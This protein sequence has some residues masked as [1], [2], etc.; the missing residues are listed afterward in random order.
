M[1]R[2][3]SLFCGAANLARQVFGISFALICFVF[4]QTAAG[5]TAPEITAL[6]L[7]VPV[8]GEI[9]AKEKRSYQI[10]LAENQFAALTVEQRGI[11]VVVR[12]FNKTD[13]RAMVQRDL[14]S[15][16]E[17]REEIN[18]VAAAAGVYRLEIEG[19]MMSSPT[20]NY[21]VRLAEVRPPTAKELRLEE[22]RK[23]HNEAFLLWRAGK[24][25]EAIPLS[26]RSLAIREKEL[27]AE[28]LDVAGSL[29]NLA[30]IV[31]E[32][33]DY[34]RGVSLL[35]RAL[36]IREKF[37]GPEHLDLTISL[38]NLGEGYRVLGDYAKAEQFQ[39]RALAIREKNFPPNHPNIA[40]SISNLANLYLQKGDADKALEFELRALS[41][42]EKAFG[43]DHPNTA[44]SLNGLGDVHS[45][46]TDYKSAEVC[47]LRALSILQKNFGTDHPKTA[48][49]M[50]NLAMLYAKQ[51]DYAKAEPLLRQ[52]LDAM[53]KTVGKEHRHYALALLWL[54]TVYTD[55]GEYQ[56]AEPL[57]KQAIA[58][59]EKLFGSQHLLVILC[60]NDLARNYQ[61][62]GETAKALEVWTRAH[63]LKQK[64]I[65]LTLSTNSERQKLLY[66]DKLFSETNQYI[67]A[68]LRFAPDNP[69]ALELALTTIFESKGRVSDAMATDFAALRS[70]FNKD[71][72]ILLDKLKDVTNQLA[73]KTL[74]E[75]PNVKPD[76][77]QKQIK[78]LEEEKERLEIEISRRSSEFR[79][80]IQ[81]VTIASIRA[82][83]PENA[84]LIEFGIYYPYDPKVI[85]SKG[86]G[87]PRY[88]AYVIRREGKIQWKDL[89]AA[90][91][92]DDA[93]ENFR[94]ALSDKER[95]DVRQIARTVDEKVMQPVRGLTGD[96]A[97]LLISPDGA[98]NLIPFEAL[99]DEQNKYLVENYSFTYLTGGRDLLRMQVQRTSKNKSLVIANPT[100]GEPLGELPAK[101]NSTRKAKGRSITATRDLSETYFAPLGG[102]A[103]EA[104]SIKTIFPEAAFL[105]GADAT[106]TALKQTVAPRILHIATHGFFLEDADD[107][108]SLLTK[109]SGGVKTVVEN[110]LLRSGLALAG[111]NRRDGAGDDGILT[112]LEA[113]GLNLWGT[114]L[115]VLSA[116]DTGIGDV[117]N[118]EGVYGLRRAFVLA[119]TE[120]MVMSLWSVSDS[121]TR[122]LMTSYY[123]NLKSGMGR[124]AALRQVQ[125]EMLKKKDREHPFYWAAFIQSGEWANLEGSR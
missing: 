91:P 59:G 107:P 73:R 79:S 13:E 114:K 76:E 61:A 22:A 32:S 58:I 89:G 53:E 94:Q 38:A 97:H 117:K 86:Y 109:R 125:L 50:A 30:G 28:D 11:D 85:D 43:P 31:L 71:D 87:E 81:P 101:V 112:A 16:T 108:E 56:K 99:T 48:D 52:T 40:F 67:S 77:H 119:G 35:E 80:Q 33:G 83:I 47:Y 26:E 116:C 95:K 90:K 113:S 102:T 124:G 17:G 3:T 27:G 14:I 68:H 2:Q 20:G 65:Q 74:S 1:Y 45:E 105:N 44:Q 75:T 29:A 18:F 70:R 82:A 72:Q 37:L 42:L 120:S 23:L 69:A 118:G 55:T 106:E 41:I 123:K 110:P 8:E 5:Q 10:N 24:I 66:L 51:G 19:K 34:E 49:V 104:R 15:K 88:V 78:E 64:L 121:V 46:K 9:A 63:Q 60:L 36:K 62:K 92:I 39:Q 100:F 21:T 111:A 103:E 25:A 98:L 122:E 54:A 115:V 57:Y 7:G 84:A 93:I 12:V 96:A 4:F 6:E